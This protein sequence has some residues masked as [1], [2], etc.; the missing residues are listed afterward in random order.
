MNY[1]KDNQDDLQALIG[2]ETMDK[3]SSAFIK[4]NVTPDNADFH[5]LPYPQLNSL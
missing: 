1:I 3:V 4:Y 2:Q 5:K